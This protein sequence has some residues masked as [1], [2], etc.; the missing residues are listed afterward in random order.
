MKDRA[1]Q[2]ALNPQYDGYQRGLASI[3]YP[4]SN[5]KIGSGVNVNEVPAQELQKPVT[6][7]FKRKKVY[8]AFKDNIWVADLAEMGLLSSFNRGVKYLFCVIDGFIKNVWVKPCTNKK[9]KNVIDGFIGILNESKCKP[10]K[11]W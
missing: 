9:A 4:F 11:L 1:Y 10:N 6:K 2:I 7:K 5:K 8:S 3:V